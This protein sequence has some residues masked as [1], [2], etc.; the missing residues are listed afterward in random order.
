[1]RT[2]NVINIIKLHVTIETGKSNSKII[3]VIGNFMT[4]YIKNML[5]SKKLLSFC[6]YLFKGRVRTT[7][8]ILLYIFFVKEV[9]FLY[10]IIQFLCMQALTPQEKMKLRMQKAL[11][12]QRKWISSYNNAYFF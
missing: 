2:V 3:H 8:S 11:N 1:M 4:Y 12:K 9:L 5:R 7:E 10:F 6:H